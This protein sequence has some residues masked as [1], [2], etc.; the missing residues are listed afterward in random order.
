MQRRSAHALLIYILSHSKLE[1][2]II[3][4]CIIGYTRLYNELYTFV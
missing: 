1:D 2:D 3:H 4:V